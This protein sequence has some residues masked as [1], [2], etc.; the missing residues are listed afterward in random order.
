MVV[1]KSKKMDNSSR[2][3]LHGEVRFRASVCDGTG[4]QYVSNAGTSLTPSTDPHSKLCSWRIVEE[5][6]DGELNQK[7]ED[8]D[9]IQ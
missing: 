8:R 2:H 5:G 3:A 9:L 6:K 4:G 1:C 7:W